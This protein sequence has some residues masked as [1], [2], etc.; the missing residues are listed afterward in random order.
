MKGIKKLLKSGKF[1]IIYW[2]S[3]EPTLYRGHWDRDKEYDR[4]EYEE[5]NK[6]VIELDGY[7]DGY[8]PEIVAL[9]T[10]ALGGVADSI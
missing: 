6:H 1:T 8:L 4:D 7:D 5:M 10:E 9:L 3:G 2:D